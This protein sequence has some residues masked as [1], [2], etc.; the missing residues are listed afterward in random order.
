MKVLYISD[1]REGGIKRHVQCL[2]T[3]LPPEVSHYT[4]GEDEPFVGKSGHDVRAWFQIRR[5]VK[6]FNP[7]IVHF[8]TPNLLMAL[9]VR[10]FSKVKRVCSWHT[11]TNRP[12]S[13]SQR[14]F[15]SVLGKCYY[16]PVSGA[17]WDGL[18]KWLPKA[19]GEVF[20]NP[21][22]I[23][24]QFEEKKSGS[25]RVVGMVGRAV[26]QKDWPGF[27]T[28]EKFVH[29]QMPEVRFLNAG[30]HE[31]CDGRAAIRAMDVFVMTSKHEQLPTTMLECFAEKTAICGFIPVG[32]TQEVLDFSSGPLKSV[33]IK[34]RD[35]R[36]L[37]DIVM[38]L[39]RDES[40][41]QSLVEDGWQILT[42]HFDADKNVK[43]QLMSIYRKIL[44]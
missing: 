18:K 7:D 28:V 8:H 31:L 9:Y 39:L 1:R 44:G 25:P 20:F 41:R 19:M 42:R 24:G 34:E 14:L 21:L 30:E 23:S 37:A 29:G 13:R 10:L 36:E 26:D 22:K 6:T 35:C 16:L 32:G 38:R 2:R 33:F 17:T 12:V 43:G 15:F 3:C 40:L 27:H 5:V 4:I 11:P